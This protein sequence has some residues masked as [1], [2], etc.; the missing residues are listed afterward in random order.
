M[1][2]QNTGRGWF[3]LWAQAGPLGES[4]ETGQLQWGPL[5]VEMEGLP[6]CEAPPASVSPWVRQMCSGDAVGLGG[7][8]ALQSSL[9]GLLPQG[10]KSCLRVGTWGVFCL[11]GRVLGWDSM[12]ISFCRAERSG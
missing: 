3:G 1:G 7:Q 12:G 9:W 8:R 4:E 10:G 11:W 6:S 2:A 5:D